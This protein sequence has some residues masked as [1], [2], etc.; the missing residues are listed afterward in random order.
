MGT[1]GAHTA[2]GSAADM[3]ATFDRAR[4]RPRFWILVGLLMLQGVF[5]Y[6]DFFVVGFLVSIIGSA[7][8]LTYGEVSIVLLAAGLGQLLGAMPFAWAADRWGRKPALIAGMLLYSV[9][10]GCAALVPDGNWQLFALLRFLVGV[11]YGGTQ[12]TLLIEF[13]PTRLRTILAGST[14]IVAPLGVLAASV[15]VASLAPVIGW[16]GLALIGF[17]PIVMVVA[18]LF[19]IPESIRWLVARGRGEEARRIIAQYVEIPLAQIPLAPAPL[20]G[21]PPRLRDL[22]RY[23]GR[24]WQVVAMSAGLGMAGFGV[25]LW[26][27]T[28][29]SMVLR[30]TTAEAAEYF[31]FVSVAGIVGRIIWT[32]TPHYIGRW[33]SALICCWGAAVCMVGAALLHSFF[34]AGVPV[35]LMCLIIGA[36]FYDG[37][38]ANTVPFGTELYP[39]RMAA[40][41]GGL[42]QVTSGFA[43]LAGPVLLALIAGSDNVLSPKATDE[44]IVPGFLCLAA[45]AAAGGLALLLLR[46]ESHGRPMTLDEGGLDAQQRALGV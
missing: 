18:L 24:F 6:F 10:A 14:S 40:Q 16:R 5:E 35:F 36:L 28:I 42:T 43:K 1:A 8:H 3:L 21:E 22:Y 30:I 33:R 45:F 11:G 2:S 27:P 12:I 31:V 19:F 41:G 37:G 17:A 9:A 34:I 32:F 44:A 20:R 7:W 4:L 46:Y 26:G 15:L 25:A 29:I 23:P 39:V 38:Y 13:A